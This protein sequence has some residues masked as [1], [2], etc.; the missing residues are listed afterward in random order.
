M[1]TTVAIVVLVMAAVALGYW[2]AY[3]T[4]MVCL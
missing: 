4:I 3:Q 1:K 2:M